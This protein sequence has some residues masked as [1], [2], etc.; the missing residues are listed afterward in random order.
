MNRKLYMPLLMALVLVFTSCNKKM[1]ELSSDYFNVT[2]QPLVAVGGQVP[3]TIYGTF[4]EKYFNKKS[5][6]TVTPVLVYAGG[7]TASTPFV[8]QGEKV[9]GNDMAIS[10]KMGGN[11]T[12]KTSFKYIPEMRNSELYLQFTVQK[13]KKTYTLPRVK[14]A[15]GVIATSELATAEGVAPAIAPDKFQRII[16]DNYVAKILF[17]IQQS[18]LR[19][20]QT[21]SS[22]MDAVKAAMLATKN[23][24]N[25][26]IADINVAGTASPDG[27]LS[28]NTN[29]AESREKN[30]VK[31]IDRKSV[32]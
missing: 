23:V 24:D 21:N 30:T 7:E 25:Q 19:S 16:T 14:V 27:P 4:P 2:P 15:D 22:E 32:V 10:Y 1:G 26:R 18:N 3:A 31:F 12:M 17:L 28:L 20:N 13:G 6:M 8:Y 5:V 29:L 11:I 9:T